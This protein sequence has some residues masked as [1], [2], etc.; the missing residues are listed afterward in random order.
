MDVTSGNRR[1]VSEILAAVLMLALTIV[2]FAL[3]APLLVSNTQTSASSIIT[4]LRDGAIEEGQSLTL[5]YQFSNFGNTTSKPYVNFGLLD[6]GSSPVTIEYV[7]VF[8]GSQTYD[9]TTN[10]T[11][12]NVTQSPNSDP[13][14]CSQTAPNCEIQPQHV[15][16]LQIKPGADSAA[17]KAMDSNST[18]QL[19]L[20]SSDDQA[21]T[22]T[23]SN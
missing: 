12:T 20:Y 3:I 7:F 16:L 11:L 14:A 6:Y 8:S 22:F 19:V 23:G 18:Y 10:S 13:V 9:L 2:G 21:Y 15:S 5:V 1:G 17:G 4:Q